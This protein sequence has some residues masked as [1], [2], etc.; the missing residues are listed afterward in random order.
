MEANLSNKGNKNMI[1]LSYMQWVVV[2]L[3][4]KYYDVFIYS[5]FHMTNVSRTLLNISQIRNEIRF[6]LRILT[7][8]KLCRFG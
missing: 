1:H 8:S 6:R 7:K 2:A 4:L 5:N 3:N